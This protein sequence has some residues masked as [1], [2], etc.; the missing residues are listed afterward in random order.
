MDV[1]CSTNKDSQGG[2]GNAIYVYNQTSSVHIRT[3]KS[4]SK[5]RKLYM[6]F[7]INFLAARSVG[8]GVSL[9]ESDLALRY[10]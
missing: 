9:L 8:S 10:T 6:A 5:I 2:F 4:Y 7:P 3:F 1:N